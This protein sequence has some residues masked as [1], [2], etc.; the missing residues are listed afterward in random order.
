[1]DM[2]QHF[3]NPAMIR[4]LLPT[5]LI[6]ALITL[7]IALLQTNISAQESRPPRLF[8][9]RQAR[10]DD[11]DNNSNAITTNEQQR[12]ETLRFIPF[13]KFDNDVKSR[14]APILSHPSIYRRLTEQNVPC[15][16]DV[17]SFLVSHPDVVISIWEKL[18]STQIVLCEVGK[19]KFKMEESSGTTAAAEIIYSNDELTV[20]YIKGV[21]RAPL[22]PKGVEGETVV[23]LRN[24]FSTNDNGIAMVNCRLDAFVNVNNHGADLIAKLIMPMIT[25]VA[26]GNFEQTVEFAGSVSDAISVNPANVYRMSTQLQ[27]ISESTRSEFQQLITAATL[28]QYRLNITSDPSQIP[29]RLVNTR[30]QEA[31]LYTPTPITY[32]VT[33]EL[34]KEKKADNLFQPF[35]EP[36]E[37]IGTNIDNLTTTEIPPE[38]LKQP[39]SKPKPVIKPKGVVFKTPTITKNRSDML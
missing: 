12:Q 18:G 5:A 15:S 22:L 26:D 10:F 17:F 19:D 9:K 38:K 3:R 2:A 29:S 33:P 34:A 23:V 39:E 8:G 28:A 32:S 1:M 7:F 37:I 35:L 24:K 20:V 11:T 30:E 27:H 13:E 16:R 4:R 21:F 31:E 25:K 36:G 14:I 6:I